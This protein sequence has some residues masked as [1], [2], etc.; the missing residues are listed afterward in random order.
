MHK[1]NALCGI[2]EGL[3]LDSFGRNIV[4]MGD[5]IYVACYPSDHY[6]AFFVHVCF[7]FYFCFKVARCLLFCGSDGGLWKSEL[8]VVT[9]MFGS[10]WRPAL[11][12]R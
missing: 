6:F 4:L 5:V 2:K 8:A 1:V 10:S 11:I 7:I 9:I 12:I 3:V